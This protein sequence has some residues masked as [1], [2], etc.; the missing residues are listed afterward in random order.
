MRILT[1]LMF[2]AIVSVSSFGQTSR[3]SSSSS[4][5]AIPCIADAK[6]LNTNGSL[7]FS[8]SSQVP[9][10]ISLLAHVSKGTPCS[11]AEIRVTATFLSDTQEFI[12][13]GTIPQAMTLKSEVQAFNI[14]IRPFMQQDFFRWRNQPGA[15]GL[16]QGKRLNCLNLDGT[17]DV[18]DI[19][20]SKAE[21]V[22]ITV[23]VMP[24]S[25]LA[26][27]EALIHINP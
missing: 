19:D 2:M 1:I 3:S 24:S 4:D 12:C 5:D 20:R 18:G 22:R 23:A 26:V 13:S 9:V 17:V 8:R 14:E 27:I 11:D 21:W 15:R 25:G 10:P 16:Q 7:N 6:W